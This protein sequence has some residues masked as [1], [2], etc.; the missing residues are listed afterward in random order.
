MIFKQTKPLFLQ[1][2]ISERRRWLLAGELQLQ[3]ARGVRDVGG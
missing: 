3:W 2:T 1:K